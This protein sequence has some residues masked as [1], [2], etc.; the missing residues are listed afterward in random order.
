MKKSTIKSAKN[1]YV[2]LIEDA[3]ELET[4]LGD[5]VTNHSTGDDFRYDL[6]KV[7]SEMFLSGAAHE[8]I[9]HSTCVFDIKDTDVYLTKWKALASA[10]AYQVLTGSQI[11][12]HYDSILG[13]CQIPDCLINLK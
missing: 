9:L 3:A 2:P 12:R 4:K 8:E 11:K 7:L 5:F 1:I 13:W 6:E 10:F